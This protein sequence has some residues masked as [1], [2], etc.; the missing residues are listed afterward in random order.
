MAKK[1]PAFL[2]YVGDFLTGTMFMSHE[3]IGIY[4]RLLCSQHQHGGFIEKISFRSMVGQHEIIFSKFI[5]TD[6]GFYNVRLMEE[7]ELRSV[8][9]SNI[10]KAAHDTWLKRKNTIVQNVDTILLQSDSDTNTKP[11]KRST[12]AIR[13]KDKDEVINYF[14]ENGYRKDVAEKVY[15]YY[16]E[17]D[18]HDSKGNKVLNWKQKCQAVWF[19]EENK[20]VE[21]QREKKITW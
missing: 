12:K 5:E 19:K 21:P 13:P 8:K 6:N 10:S 18:W 7:M 3:Q 14:I 11:K 9:S 15:Q 16:E 4:I 2:F 17:A 1:D 20:S